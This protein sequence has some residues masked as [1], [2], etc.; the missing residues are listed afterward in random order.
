MESGATNTVPSMDQIQVETV[1]AHENIDNIPDFYYWSIANVCIS[2]VILGL[3]ACFF[4]Q[5]VCD[6]KASRNMEKAKK[7]SRVTLCWNI[8]A[9]L[10]GIAATA[11]VIGVLVPQLK[12][13]Y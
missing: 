5:N 2:G 4:S 1:D 13:H 3:V 8:V 12:S 10:I 7:W 11:I 9:T 6:Y